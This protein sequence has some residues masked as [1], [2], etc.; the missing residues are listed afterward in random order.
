MMSVMRCVRSIAHTE[1]Y[2]KTLT[3]LQ[4]LPYEYGGSSTS[5]TENNDKAKK[6]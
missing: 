1:R 4:N 5:H 2:Q 6:E 3:G